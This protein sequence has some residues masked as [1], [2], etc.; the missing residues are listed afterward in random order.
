[1]VRR[2]AIILIDYSQISIS[3]LHT[4]LKRESEQLET[5]LLRHMILNS[6]R[7]VNREFGPVYGDIVICSDNENYW[8]KSFFK[9][10]KANRKKLRD[11]SGIDWK[12]VF[13]TL[14]ELR[15]ELSD[16]FPYKVLNVHMAEADDVI[17][18]IVKHHSASERILI[19]SGDHDFMQLQSYPNVF[20]YA[21]AQNNFL[22]TNDPALFLKEHILRGDTGD[23]IPNFLSDDNVFVTNTR[24][25]SLYQTKVDVYVTQQPE[26][27]CDEKQ[28]QNYNRNKTL[29]DLSQIP[30]DV[31]AAIVDA[32]AQP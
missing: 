23:G 4:Q 14:N 11:D 31:E 16:T 20:Q 12:L 28:L 1:M 8:R 21:P 10:Y 7:K 29:V 32:F 15:Q 6:I 19:Y 3:N 24:Q 13:Q 22:Q 25:K 26:E 27:F 9:Y 2:C 30:S 18:I 5:N 17:A